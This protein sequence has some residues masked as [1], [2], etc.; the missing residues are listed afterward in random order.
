MN[1]VQLARLKV[2]H[3]LIALAR[4]CAVGSVN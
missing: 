3:V 2:Q 1:M 4:Q